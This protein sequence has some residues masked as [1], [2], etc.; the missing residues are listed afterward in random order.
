MPVVLFGDVGQFFE[1]V[2]FSFF[3][4]SIFVQLMIVVSWI[5]YATFPYTQI[6]P[7]HNAL[8]KKT[9]SMCYILQDIF[10]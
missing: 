2:E 3:M 4:V 1:W 6:A 5:N 8:E 7:V 9:G 10:C